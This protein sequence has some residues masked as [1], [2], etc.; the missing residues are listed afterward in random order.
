MYILT[1]YYVTRIWHRIKS[2]QNSM[3]QYFNKEYKCCL[4]NRQWKTNNSLTDWGSSKYSCLAK[5][6]SHFSCCIH[7][8]FTNEHFPARWCLHLH[9][10]HPSDYATSHARRHLPTE[11]EILHISLIYHCK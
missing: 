11:T 5:T 1:S 3:P 9:G 8:L 7:G 2:P 4:W 6:Q 10:G